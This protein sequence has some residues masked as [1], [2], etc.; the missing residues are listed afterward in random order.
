MDR[1]LTNSQ[2]GFLLEFIS[3][4]VLNGFITA[5]AITIILNQ[6]DSLLGQTNIGDGTAAQVSLLQCRSIVENPSLTLPDTRHV[7]PIRSSQRLRMCHRFRRYHIPHHHRKSRQ[8][9][10]RQEQDPLVRHHHPCLPLPRPLHRHFVR[11]QRR[12]CRGG[13]SLRDRRGQLRRHWHARN[14]P[15]RTH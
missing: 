3:L 6:M 8:T 4:P 10:R 2:L 14:A 9:L 11:R 1:P 15:T 5:I 13:L 7:R 12:P